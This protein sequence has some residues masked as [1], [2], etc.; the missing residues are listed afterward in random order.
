[1]VALRELVVE[2]LDRPLE[3][4][5]P[6][7]AGMEIAEKHQ[8][9]AREPDLLGDSAERLAEA[10]QI[11]KG[12]EEE[13]V[14]PEAQGLGRDLD[15]RLAGE[16]DDLHRREAGPHRLH[17]G[18]PFRRP[19]LGIDDEDVV[20]RVLEPLQALQRRRRDVVRIAVLEEELLHHPAL[21]RIL[22][23]EK[24][25]RYVHR[26]SQ[27]S[28]AAGT[29]ARKAGAAGAAGAARLDSCSFVFATEPPQAAL[30]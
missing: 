30:P 21:L 20:G 24:D 8:V 4:R 10:P 14:G 18:Q 16:R 11:G 1:M 27:P 12:L 28:S 7:V 29:C 22:L 3:A 23:D 2:L 19:H 6:L 15:G 5:E 26:A 25:A 17:Q 9:L 13:V